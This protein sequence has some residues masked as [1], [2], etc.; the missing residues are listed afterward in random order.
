MIKDYVTPED[1]VM[2]RHLD[3]KL[4]PMIDYLTKCRPLSVSMGNAIDFVKLKIH[5][6]DPQL[7]DDKVYF[8]SNHFYQI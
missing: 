5:Q 1:K 6:L 8:F 4:R 3:Q 7:P 2:N